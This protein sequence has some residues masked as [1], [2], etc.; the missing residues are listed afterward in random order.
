LS[1]F[2]RI[3]QYE[4]AYLDEEE[5]E[6]IVNFHLSDHPETLWKRALFEVLTNMNEV[7]VSLP[8]VFPSSL[9]QP[10]HKAALTPFTHHHT[11]EL[12]IVQPATP[13]KD[14]PSHFEEFLYFLQACAILDLDFICIRTFSFRKDSL[15]SLMLRKPR[16]PL[17]YFLSHSAR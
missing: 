7:R 12:T 15:V 16:P 5:W 4:G 6:D 14:G 8:Q 3:K 17:I 10:C 2:E 11:Q 13:Y 9:Q 1:G